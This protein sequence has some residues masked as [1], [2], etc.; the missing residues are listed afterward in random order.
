MQGN[1]EY[2]CQSPCCGRELQE[3]F[4]AAGTVCAK[5][6]GQECVDVF[7]QEPA[8]SVAEQ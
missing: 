8:A 4:W 3:G 2:A 6:L 7:R 1:A 5:A